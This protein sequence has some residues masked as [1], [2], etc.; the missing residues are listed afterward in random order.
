MQNGVPCRWHIISVQPTMILFTTRQVLQPS[1]QLMQVA[2]T[3]LMALPGS[4][5]A[6]TVVARSAVRSPLEARGSIMLLLVV[7]VVV[8]VVIEPEVVLWVLWV[9]VCH[10]AHRV[11]GTQVRRLGPSSW[12]P[13]HDR[14]SCLLAPAPVDSLCR[15]PIFD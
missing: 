5:W 15:F 2:G 1:F 14:N 3:A 13:H 7:V 6:P 10:G 4:G 12:R 9:V 8:M 11:A